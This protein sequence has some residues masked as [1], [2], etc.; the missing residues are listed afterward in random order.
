MN[1]KAFRRERLLC[2]AGRKG[3][4]SNIFVKDLLKITDFLNYYGLA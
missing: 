4:I 3:Q 1:L 2:F